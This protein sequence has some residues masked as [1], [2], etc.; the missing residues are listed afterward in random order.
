MVDADGDTTR[1]KVVRSTTRKELRRRKPLDSLLRGTV[2]GAVAI[3]AERICFS[4]EMNYSNSLEE[5]VLPRKTL[6]PE[7]ATPVTPNSRTEAII[8]ETAIRAVA[9]PRSRVEE[10]SKDV[11]KSGLVLTANS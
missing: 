9:V 3:L 7:K 4:I 6:G 5:A 2:T 1:T 11:H 10:D 8:T